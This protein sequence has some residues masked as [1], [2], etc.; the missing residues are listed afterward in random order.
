MDKLQVEFNVLTSDDW[1]LRNSLVKFPFT[2][3]VLKQKLVYYS[4]E[5]SL[6]LNKLISIYKFEIYK[7]TRHK[8]LEQA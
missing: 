6:N 5:K 1:K 3:L 7:Q 4:N 8:Y 2:A